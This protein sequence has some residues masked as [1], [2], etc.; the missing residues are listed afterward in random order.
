MG[1]MNVGNET[2]AAA[3]RELRTAIR[4]KVVVRGDD[5]YSRTRLALERC[6]QSSAGHIC[7]LRRPK[8]FRRS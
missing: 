8:N 1:V 4:G 3:T 7:H 6:R 5:A 2:L